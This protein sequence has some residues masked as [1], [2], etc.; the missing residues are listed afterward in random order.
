MVRRASCG[1][2]H[3]AGFR[4]AN[5]RARHCARCLSGVG[6]ARVPAT[7]ARRAALVVVVRTLYKA[8]AQTRGLSPS[9]QDRGAMCQLRPPTHSWLSRGAHVSAPLRSLSLGG[10]CSTHACDA[11]AWCRPGC[12]WLVPYTN[13]LHRRDRPPS[14]RPRRARGGRALAH[15]LC[16]DTRALRVPLERGDV[17][18]QR[19][20]ALS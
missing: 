8:T 19:R 7:R 9:A 5:A 3:T 11:R 4:V 13:P 18:G 2:Q 17:H 15:R 16:C 12:S 6:A 1:L 20:E 10:R 14:P